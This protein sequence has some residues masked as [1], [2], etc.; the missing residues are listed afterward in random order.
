MKMNLNEMNFCTCNL[1]NTFEK[2]LFVL[3]SGMLSYQTDI[4]GDKYLVI[5][6]SSIRFIFFY[7]ILKGYYN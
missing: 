2:K 3:L 6:K 4:N 1:E 7:D 5:L